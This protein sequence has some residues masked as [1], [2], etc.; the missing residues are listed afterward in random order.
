MLLA[1]ELV[2]HAGQSFRG[3]AAALAVMALHL[4]PSLRTPCANTIQSWVLRM[5]HFQLHRPLPPGAD[6][7]WLID[8]TL[9]IGPHKILAIVGCRL[10]DM[11]WGQRS[12]A[13]TDLQ[14]LHLAVLP[15][16]THETIL[17]ALQVA[18]ERVGLPRVIVTDGGSELLKAI[19]LFREE[20]RTV[21]H[22]SDLAHVGA[23]LLK[24]RFTA[25]ARWSEFLQQLTQTNQKVRQTE[26]AYLLSPRLR[27]KG[28]FMSVGVV[29]RFVRRVLYYLEQPSADARGVAAYGWLEGF[30][31]DVERWWLEQQV[32]QRTVE[33]V[34]RDGWHE[35]VLRPLER[36]WRPVSGE[37]QVELVA[38]LRSFAKATLAQLRPEERLPGST[39]ALES[40]FGRWKRLVEAG[41]S[42]GV[43][44]M[45]LA[46]GSVLKPLPAE[47]YVSAMRETP[48]KRVWKWLSD[49]IGTTMQK[50]RK[51]FQRQTAA[52]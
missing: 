28:R 13:T 22:V 49:H 2:V 11:P 37:P 14:L 21:A 32:V 4:S 15:R 33:T 1:T 26:L 42:V 48:L 20:R 25:D 39:E 5:G 52:V 30:R 40:C 43:S 41:P 38:S 46:L 51:R 3:A 27:D 16:S 31:A 36:L 35:G 29:L 34:R 23:N 17:P 10:R 19:R 9:T 50:L 44:R 24:K 8:E 18:Q 7:A 47:E 6:W 12:L 45:A